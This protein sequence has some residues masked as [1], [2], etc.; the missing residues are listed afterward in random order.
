MPVPVGIFDTEATAVPE[1]VTVEDLL[2]NE[3]GVKIVVYVAVPPAAIVVAEGNDTT[4]CESL[5]LTAIPD[6]EV[7]PLLVMV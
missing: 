3:V 7:N 4:N 2:P 5:E 6:T 1:T